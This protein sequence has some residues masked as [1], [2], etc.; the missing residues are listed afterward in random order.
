MDNR[1][2]VIIMSKT[3]LRSGLAVAVRRLVRLGCFL[4]KS[5]IGK[6][7]RPGTTYLCPASVVQSLQL[8]RR[9]PQ[10]LLAERK[11]DCQAILGDRASVQEIE[12]RET[13]RHD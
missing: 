4:G 3:K 5:A 12:S 7:K 9:S 6:R 13:P 1:E 2:R 11:P 8:D 10:S